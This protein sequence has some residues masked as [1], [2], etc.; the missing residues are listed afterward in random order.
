MRA[1]QNILNDLRAFNLTA[2]VLRGGTPLAQL[3]YL[4]GMYVLSLGVNVHNGVICYKFE[5]G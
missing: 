5:A 4:C 2:M 3:C 1:A